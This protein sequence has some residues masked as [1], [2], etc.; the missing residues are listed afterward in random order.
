[1][2]VRNDEGDAGLRG[3]GVQRC[4]EIAAGDAEIFRVRSRSRERDEGCRRQKCNF[5]G[6]AVHSSPACAA[7]AAV[8]LGCA[9]R[10][11]TISSSCF[12][13]CRPKTALVTSTNGSTSFAGNVPLMVSLPIGPSPIT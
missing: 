6:N 11:S 2:V 8:Q 10:V 3:V 9:Q 4:F 12:L 13:A 7:V 1:R 5:V